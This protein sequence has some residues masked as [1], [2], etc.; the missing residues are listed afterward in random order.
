MKRSNLIGQFG[1]VVIELS[2]N[3]QGYGSSLQ[4]ASL[5][6]FCKFM[7]ISRVFC[8]ANLNV[9]YLCNVINHSYYLHF[10]FVVR[11]NISEAISSYALVTFVTDSQINSNSGQHV[12]IKC[13][14]T[15]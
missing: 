15:K 9:G 13:F 4:Q 10:W 8:E 14:K 12:F 3:K 6:C 7:C 2:I 1:K 5:L 11:M